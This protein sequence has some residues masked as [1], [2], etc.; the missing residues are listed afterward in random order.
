MPKVSIIVPV[1]NSE[2]TL[3][4][5]LSTLLNQTLQDIEIIIVNDAGTDSSVRII[6]DAVSQ[7]PGKIVFI[8]SPVNG[9]PGGAKNLALDIAKGEYIGF[10]DSDDVVR[11][12]MF[13]LLYNKAISGNYDI[14]DA[15]FYDEKKDTAI[16]YT[17]DDLTG[18]LNDTQRSKLIASGGYLCTKIFRKSLWNTPQISTGEPLRFRKHAIL[19]DCETLIYLLSVAKSIGN[20][21][22]ILYVYKNNEGSQSKL[23]DADKYSENITNAIEALHKITAPLPVYSGIRDAVEYAMYQ[24]YCY[25]VIRCL[26]AIK[27][28]GRN[29]L[30][31]CIT[32]LYSL[33]SKY[34]KGSPANNPYIK[35]KIPAGDLNILAYVEAGK[36]GDL[37]AQV[38][39]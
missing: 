30:K 28:E 13:E 23:M 6:Q 2:K 26:F 38:R 14:V 10:V 1:Y 7:F 31:S 18:N 36:L 5:T 22:E 15:G 21:K 32:N 12:D 33:I 29:D 17:S 4:N 8:D 16:L 9:G 27:D 39:R 3:A 35:E 34:V 24:M 37:I 20:V 25:G 19:E 11:N